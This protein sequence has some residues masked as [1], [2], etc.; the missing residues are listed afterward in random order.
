MR[1]RLS[2]S[3]KNLWG[4]AHLDINKFKKCFT[5]IVVEDAILYSYNKLDTFLYS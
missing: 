5:I 1:F 3:K 2:L 4:N